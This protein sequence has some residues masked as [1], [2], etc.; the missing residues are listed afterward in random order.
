[1]PRPAAD[2]VGEVIAGLS[3]GGHRRGEPALGPVA[4]GARQRRRGHERDPRPRARGAQGRVH[5]RRAGADGDQLIATCRQGEVRYIR[6]QRRPCSST[7]RR[8]SSTSRGRTRSSP[9]G[10]SRVRREL[11]RLDWLGYERRCLAGGRALRPERGALVGVHQ[12]RS[13]GSRLDGGGPL[14]PDTVISEGSYMA[15][16]HAAGGAVALVDICSPAVA[17]ARGFSAHRPPGHHALHSRAMGFCVFNNIAVA[18]RYAVAELGLQAGAGARLGRAPRQRHQRRV[19]RQRR[20]AV[21]L[22]PRVAAVSGHRAAGG[23]RRGR[24]PRLHRQSAGS[25]GDAAMPTTC[26][27]SGTWSCRS[28]VH[29]SRNWC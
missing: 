19:L 12:L 9:A 25:R 8:R 20:G 16:L 1:M 3:V 10:S 27:S 14:D 6:W 7:I 22:D 26:R 17:G 21:H 24:G 15:A 28:R 18:A 11:E 5:A 2:R 23:C 29:S 13:S 4:G